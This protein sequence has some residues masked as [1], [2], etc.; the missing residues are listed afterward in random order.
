MK[1]RSRKWLLM[2]AVVGALGYLA[3]RF[4]TLLNLANFSAANLWSTIR[5][6][7]LGLLCLALLLIYACYAVRSLRWQAMQRNIGPSRF[8]DIY[9]VTLAGFAAVNILSR[10]GEPIR[11]LLL[12]RKAKHPVA[13]IFGIWAL[14]RLI[15]TASFAIILAIGLIAYRPRAGAGELSAT[16]AAAKVGGGVLGA[17][18]AG[19]IVLLAYLRLHGSALL[20]ARMHGWT[21]STGWRVRSAKIVLGFVRGIQ[22]IKSWSDLI[23]TVFYSVLHW[24]L[25]LVV[26]VFVCKSFGGELGQL[27][28]SD[29]TMLLGLTLVG[30]IIQLPAVGGGF[31][32]AAF[33]VF[34]KLFGI[35]A[36]PATAAALLLWLVAFVACSLVGIPVLIR[37]GVSL[38]QL[39]E[40]AV[41]EKEELEEI[42]VHGSAE[43]NVETGVGPGG[44]GE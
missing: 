19:V 17:A 6:I 11:P 42:A 9:T 26:Y 35:A 28:F 21:A 34:T 32:T 36:E 29:C 2:A 20:E 40:L 43:P 3:Y 38:G 30:S 8:L 16:I 22:T 5:G 44:K 7:N 15:D 4:R 23:T 41:Q 27:G 10:A 12:A 25:V 14:E 33:V 39:R 13:D 31:Q 24:V 1:P 37:E 18:V